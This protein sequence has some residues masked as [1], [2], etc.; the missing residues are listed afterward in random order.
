MGGVGGTLI[1]NVLSPA[2]AQA[3]LRD[4][5]T[6]EAFAR[7]IATPRSSAASL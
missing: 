5:L 3:T 6:G 2:A 4:L 7:T 1:A